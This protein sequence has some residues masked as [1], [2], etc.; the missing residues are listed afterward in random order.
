MTNKA[1]RSLGVILLALM[2][3]GCWPQAGYGP[4][5][6]RFNH[7]ESD[8][9]RD[10]VASLSE[11]WRTPIDSVI[12][13]PIVSGGRI[14]VGAR[15]YADDGLHLDVLAVQAYDRDTGELEWEQSLIPLEGPELTGNIATPALE[16]GALWVPYWHDG[17]GPCNGELARLDPETGE[18]LSADIT[19]PE[20][21]DV[22]MAGST[23][24]YMSSTCA[25]GPQLV[26]RD[27][28]TRA[29]LWTHHFPDGS[30][31]S[32][33]TV[34]G[35]RLFLLGRGT[36]YAF[37][38]DG[39]G[40]DVCDPLWTEPVA[41]S[42]FDFLRLAAGP[43]GSLVT[44]GASSVPESRDTVVVRD[45]A[46]GDIR[47]EAEPRYT[48]SAPGAITGVTLADD[49]LYVAGATSEEPWGF[50]QAVLDAYPV[51]GCGQPVCSPTW[52]ADLGPSRPAREPTAAG[53]VVY[54]PLVADGPVA[55]AVV[56]VDAGGCGAST[57]EEVTRVPLVDASPPF[58]TGTQSNVTSVAEGGVF[59]GFLPGLYGQTQSEL[60]SLGP[61][62][63]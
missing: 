23:L 27:Q 10:N 59:V 54:V 32:T 44:F 1:F 26:V 46:T 50:N 28:E 21:S 30:G 13:E 8:L 29:V 57:C 31:V 6:T 48:G 22:V 38:A 20:P 3:A 25:G 45:G 60:I 43:D 37:D 56:A 19:G 55:P 5:N 11:Q 18:V 36:L 47:W 7:R 61:S 2:L 63:S 15:K 4:G 17:L 12:T 58:L 35:G 42:F 41:R 9:T 16:D 52:T 40:A 34:A 51:G 53:G 39:C 49:T 14:Y 24:A 62:E 33:P